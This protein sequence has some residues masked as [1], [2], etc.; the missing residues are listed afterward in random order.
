V[1]VAG[2]MPCG[3]CRQFL[4][5]WAAESA[6]CIV[7]QVEQSV[8]RS[9]DLEGRPVAEQEFLIAQFDDLM[10]YPFPRRANE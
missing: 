5:E 10:P 2:A 6:L 1:Y 7:E 3:S 9:T 8:L 4:W